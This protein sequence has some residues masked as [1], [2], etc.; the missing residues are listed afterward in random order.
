MAPLETQI[1]RPRINSR[2][3]SGGI[4]STVDAW[5][6]VQAVTESLACCRN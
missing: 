4:A 3:L 5:Q 1:C 2:P 6:A